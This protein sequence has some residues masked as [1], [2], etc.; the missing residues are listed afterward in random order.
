MSRR[1]YLDWLRGVGVLIMVEAHTL[2]SWTRPADHQRALYGWAIVIGGFGAPIFLLLA[3][4]ALV[5]ACESRV[6]RG[7]TPAEAARSAQ[8]RGWQIFALAFLFRLQ[9]WLISGGPV[10]GLL[11]VD[12]L[13]VMGLA[14]VMAAGLWNC[15]SARVSR[16]M[17]L[18]GAAVALAMSTPIVR[19]T[20]LLAPLPDP[21]EA[22]LRPL[23]GR[24]T[25]TLF[26][27]AGF[28][29][30]GAVAGIWIDAA[31]TDRQEGRL[32]KGFA[33]LGGLLAAA[34]YGFSFLPP[35]YPESNFWTSSPTYFF[36]RLGLLLV[37]VAAGYAWNRGAADYSP[38][39]EIGLSSLFVYWV[40]VE[41]VYG[42]L[43]A[44]LHRRLTLEAAACA[45]VLFA[46]FL[47]ALVRSKNAIF[48]GR[49]PKADI[50]VKDVQ[51]L[52][53]S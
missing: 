36:I 22:Y 47:F 40:H 29:L 20:P 31:R 21:L 42:V 13:N 34:G 24:T 51:P 16:T 8:Q 9:S 28:L 1:R 43:S 15:A 52:I 6:R 26:P 2:D 35:L 30:G 14:M 48:P 41:M 19:A 4:I 7:R 45:F 27:W 53:T 46:I 49:H 3:G 39:R 38:L 10:Q 5:L 32:N 23:A 12:I 18:G 44:P 25:F 50:P 17:L 11:K 33:L 37:L